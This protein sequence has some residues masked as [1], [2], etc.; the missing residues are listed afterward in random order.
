MPRFSLSALGVDAPGIVRAVSGALADQGCNLEDSTMTVLQGHFAILMVI[1]A[2]ASCSTESLESAL[3]DAVRQFGLVIAVR[4][5]GEA[6][7][8]LAQAEGSEPLSIVIYGSDRPGIVRAIADSLAGRA[9]NVVELSSQL[10]GDPESESVYVM[11]MRALAE[12][13]TGDEVLDAVRATAEGLGV[14][15][16]ARRDDADVL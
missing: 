5:L 2:P 6:T 1:T 14:Q 12:Q 11:T 3:D 8:D 7:G 13:G 16:T 15:C 9:A 10:V 4:P